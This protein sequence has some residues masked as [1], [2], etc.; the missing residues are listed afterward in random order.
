MLPNVDAVLRQQME[1]KMGVEIEEYFD[2]HGTAV[3]TLDKKEMVESEL[4]RGQE[5]EAWLTKYE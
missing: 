5:R 4:Y 3:G 1:L 2:G